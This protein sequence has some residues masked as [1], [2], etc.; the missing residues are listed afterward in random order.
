MTLSNP[1]QH[2]VVHMCLEAARRPG[3]DCQWMM[4]HLLVNEVLKHPFLIVFVREYVCCSQFEAVVREWRRLSS[5]PSFQASCC[6]VLG[7]WGH[8]VF[9]SMQ[10]PFLPQSHSPSVTLHLDCAKPHLHLDCAPMWGKNSVESDGK[11]C[12]GVKNPKCEVFK[13]MYHKCRRY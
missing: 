2:L 4:E 7:G 5:H 8:T 11:L 13:R 6:F 1:S 12:K 9:D 10:S 3:E